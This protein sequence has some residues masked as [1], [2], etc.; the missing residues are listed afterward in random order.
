MFETSF[1]IFLNCDIPVFRVV[2][3]WLVTWAWTPST[4]PR[5]PILPVTSRCMSTVC[6]SPST[7]HGYNPEWF[8]TAFNPQIENPYA[9][10]HSWDQVPGER[11]SGTYFADH[12]IGG[13]ISLSLPTPSLMMLIN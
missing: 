8:G 9:L 2:W 12:C 6:P 5:R 10:P 13:E 1:V 4:N 11:G 3:I 7:L